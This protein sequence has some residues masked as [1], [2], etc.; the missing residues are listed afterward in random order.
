MSDIIGESTKIQLVRQTIRDVA[1][2]MA[3]VLISGETGTGKELVARTIHQESARRDNPFIVAHC[4]SYSQNLMASELFGHEKG[5]FTGA[6]FRGIGRFERAHKGTLFLDEIG[7]IPQETQVMLLRVLEEK[8]FERVGGE[9][10][11]ETDVRILAATN[12]DLYAEVAAGRFRND[13][14]YRLNV[15]GIF[16]PTLHERREDIPLLV[17]H[18]IKKYNLI[19]GK[20]VKGV[21]NRM[22]ELLINY[23]WP[24]NVRELESQINRAVVLTKGKTIREDVFSL[25]GQGDPLRKGGTLL[26]HERQ[27]ILST[28][29]A[30]HWNKHEVSRRLGIQ[31]ATLYSKI[32][33]YG[34][35]PQ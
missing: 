4:G 8:S 12:K 1:G 21:S 16:I 6:S 5:A 2:S 9:K 27:L 14:Y 35:S 17:E 11:L 24:G 7:S 10:S 29:Q 3:N 31:R 25:D 28:L 33:R 22:M 19:E 18:F 13:L 26:D 15:I 23:N 20:N 34:L 32:K 30:C